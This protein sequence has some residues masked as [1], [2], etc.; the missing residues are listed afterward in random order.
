MAHARLCPHRF[1]VGELVLLVDKSFLEVK[2]PSVQLILS[3]FAFLRAM[4]YRFLIFSGINLIVDCVPENA[5]FEVLQDWSFL[6]MLS[7]VEEMTRN[8]RL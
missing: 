4:K 1:G 2:Q 7:Q 3:H 6:A 5:N 8:G